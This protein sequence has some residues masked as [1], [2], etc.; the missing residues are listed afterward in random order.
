M[1]SA[2]GAQ[3][4]GGTSP[5]AQSSS[6]T[7]GPGQHRDR[8][9]PNTGTIAAGRL[10]DTRSAIVQLLLLG[11]RSAYS[12]DGS[13]DRGFVPKC[14]PEREW[15]LRL[16]QQGQAS[17]LRN[18]RRHRRRQWLRSPARGAAECRCRQFLRLSRRGAEFRIVELAWFAPRSDA[19]YRCR[20]FVRLARDGAE[21]SPAPSSNGSVRVVSVTEGAWRISARCGVK[22]AVR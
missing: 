1:G 17:F 6:P 12:L 13:S 16:L 8:A 19:R 14:E 7:A 15:C 10:F 3:S 11:S 5:A 18:C 20:Q 4:A 9:D 22:V 2:A 21:L